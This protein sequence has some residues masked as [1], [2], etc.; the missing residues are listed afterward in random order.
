[1]HQ[2]APSSD[3]AAFL[4]DAPCGLLQTDAQ[5]IVQWANQLFCTWVG[6]AYADIVGR[7]KI[8]DFFTTGGR[9][10]HQTHWVP[11]MQM[12]NSVSEVKFDII[13]ADGKSIPTII[14]GIRSQRSGVIVHN[15][16]LFI[17]RDRDRYERELVKASERLK[18]VAARSAELEV[19]ASDRALFAE[20]MMGVVSHDLR[21]PLATIDLSAMVVAAG[22]LGAHQQA[23]LA[24]ITRATSRA[25][26]LIHDLL[27]FTQARLG[28][29]MGI[30]RADVDLHAIMSDS[31]DELRSAFPGRELLHRAEGAG[32]CEADADRLMQLTG[33][34]V[35]NAITYGRADSPV[36][37]T[38]RIAED[39]CTISVH[40]VGQPIDAASIAVLF[41]PM[42]RGAA[43]P[44]GTRSIGLGLYIVRE[45]AKAHH[46]I[47]TVT[48]NADEGT[49]FAATFT[50]RASGTMHIG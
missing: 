10:F 22:D 19:I 50:R 28:K 25:V 36:I 13:S 18:A 38:S 12:Q 30:A 42:A 23:A 17:A 32:R 41:E 7:R 20:Q 31:V 33:N 49:T 8:Q 4:D 15:L 5:G 27:D 2:D 47:V 16:A 29:G 24:R 9:I 26:R 44:D 39:E 6:Y 21:N 45:I 14:N 11:L 1:M 3:A 34:L 37:I 35:T 40:N 46:G 43:M 48:S